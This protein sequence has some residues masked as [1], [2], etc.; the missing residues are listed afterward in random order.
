MPTSAKAEVGSSGRRASEV[1]RHAD[2][3]G[4]RFGRRRQHQV[5][6]AARCHPAREDRAGGD[7]GWQ[8]Q[9]EVP[10]FDPREELMPDSSFQ[11]L[12]A[13]LH[14][15]GTLDQGVVSGRVT[16]NDEPLELESVRFTRSEE[17]L[18]L[19]SLLKIGAT[20]GEVMANADIQF[21]EESWTSKASARWKDV[22]VP[23]AWVG[24]ELFTHGEL[25]FDGNPQLYNAKGRLTLGRKSSRRISP[26]RARHAR[27]GGVAAVRY[28]SEERSTGRD[29]QSEFEAATGV[30]RRCARTGLRSWR[31]RGRVAGQ[32]ALPI[33][34]ARK[35]DGAG[36]DATLKLTELRGKLRGRQISGDADL[37][38]TAPYLPAGTLA[39][40]SGESKLRVNAAKGEKINATIGVDVASL[41]DWLPNSGGQLAANFRV[42]GKWPDVAING[43][44]RGSE[45]HMDDMRLQQITLDADV[46]KPLDPEGSVQVRMAGLSAAGSS[47]THCRRM[48]PATRLRIARK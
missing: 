21:S 2:R 33:G 1:R 6:L 48:R 11:S 41:N 38:L 3:I 28:R 26:E 45:L 27:A 31:V 9:L 17:R 24:Q 37:T 18:T 7:H 14:G 43:N 36:P 42:L 12:A 44:A 5:V 39:L 29:R 23:S 40:N 19:E 10:R 4:E 34:H 47:S 15:E 46:N 16:I 8:L 13:S 25:N 20:A 22:V 35:D 32:S 30:G